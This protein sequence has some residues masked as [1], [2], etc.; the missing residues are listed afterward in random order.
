MVIDFLKS[1]AILTD[2]V[3]I[4][5]DLFN[6]T[7]IYMV[8]NNNANDNYK[9]SYHIVLFRSNIKGYPI[10]SLIFSILFLWYHWYQ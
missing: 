6:A 9:L 5:K 3:K 7:T 2:I 4:F 10:V 8:F 1:L